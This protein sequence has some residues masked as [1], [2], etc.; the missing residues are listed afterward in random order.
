VERFK[1]TNYRQAIHFSINI[2]ELTQLKEEA[3]KELL[4]EQIKKVVE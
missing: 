2:E 1:L 4:N 3:L